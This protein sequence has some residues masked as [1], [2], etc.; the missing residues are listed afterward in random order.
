MLGKLKRKINGW[1][2]RAYGKHPG[3]KDFFDIGSH[4]TVLKAL[5]DWVTKGFAVSDR[6]EQSMHLNLVSWRFWIQAPGENLIAG[7]VRDSSDRIGRKFPLIA[8]GYGPLKSWHRHWSIVSMLCQTSWFQ[9]EQ[10]SS[11][12]HEKLSDFEHGLDHLTHPA[13]GGGDVK[14]R[15]QELN[16][17]MNLLDNRIAQTMSASELGKIFKQDRISVPL[18][19][20]PLLT[21]DQLA[22]CWVHAFFSANPVVPKA[23]FLGGNQDNKRIVFFNR[24]IN[25]KDFKYLWHNDLHAS[26]A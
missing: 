24:P 6:Q 5:N 7:I 26:D 8:C 18:M 2:W 14:L 12:P 22:S 17:W 15:S 3:F 1:E 20:T 16:Q 11:K 9:L 4:N 13:M 23:V 21:P 25:S 19:D 10:L